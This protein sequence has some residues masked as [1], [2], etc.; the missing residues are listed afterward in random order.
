[1]AELP[2]WATDQGE[3]AKGVPIIGVDADAM[4]PAVL[5][6]Y[7][8]F[9]ADEGNRPAEWNKAD[10]ELRAEWS[11]CLDELD[12]SNPSAYWLEVAYQSMKLDLQLAM[13]RF[14]FE[15]RVHDPDR[16]W[17]QA[18]AP[19]GRGPEMAAGGSS[20]GREAR[21]H[22]KRLRGMLPG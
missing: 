6:E 17:S 19:D 9:Y 10:G 1:M 4:Y 15:I 18:D 21:E 5:S 14:G 22:F 16:A 8:E 13:R 11:E 2:S 3:S 20:G 12:P 7:A